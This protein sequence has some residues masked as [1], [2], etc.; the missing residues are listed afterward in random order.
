MP[1]KKNDTETPSPSVE[2]RTTRRAASRAALQNMA[3]LTASYI[4]EEE[5]ADDPSENFEPSTDDEVNNLLNSIT[6]F[7]CLDIFYDIDIILIYD[8]FY[9]IHTCNS[10]LLIKDY[11]NVS[12]IFYG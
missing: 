6:Y 8:I 12:I 1:K 10:N 2:P 7:I 3:K 4:G 5:D 11:V 9:D